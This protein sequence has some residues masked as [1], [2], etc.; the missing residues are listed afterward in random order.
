MIFNRLF[1][2]P[3]PRPGD[4]VLAKCASVCR[5]WQSVF[6]RNIFEV[7]VSSQ[8]CLPRLRNVV[9]GKKKQYRL[10]L[11]DTLVLRVRLDEYGC[12]VARQPKTTRP[13]GSM[14]VVFPFPFPSPAIVG[15]QRSR[16]A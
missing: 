5:N 12:S 15:R 13:S 2:D 10:A 1:I 4:H 7:L 3:K 16:Q 14:P 6:E 11:I 9:R 8:Q